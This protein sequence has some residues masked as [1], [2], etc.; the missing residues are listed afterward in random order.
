MKSIDTS[1]ILFLTGSVI[2]IVGS[3]AKFIE[4][5][6]AEPRA[7]YL[8][9]T[10]VAMLIYVQLKH[11]Y[12]N[13]KAETRQKRLALNGLFSSLLLALGVY[14]MFKHS[15]SW[16]VAVLIYALS[17]LITSFRGENK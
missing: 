3:I 8:F 16:I 1:K 10:G 2:T 14:F 6:D 5:S 11:L 7:V 12:D 9:A 4:P 13:R 15:N 17:S